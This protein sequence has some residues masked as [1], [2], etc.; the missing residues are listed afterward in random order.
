MR[1]LQTELIEKGFSQART[2]EIDRK[3]TRTRDEH[4]ERLTARDLRDLMGSNR[5]TYERKKG[6][7]FRQR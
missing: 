3:D 2:A 5:P 6:G 7:A 1:S 4:T